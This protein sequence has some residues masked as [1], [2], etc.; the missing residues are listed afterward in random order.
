VQNS[1]RAT[2]LALPLPE[3]W[4]LRWQRSEAYHVVPMDAPDQP[5]GP[6]LAAALRWYEGVFW[7]KAR[8]TEYDAVPLAAEIFDAALHVNP[9]ETGEILAFVR[10]WGCLFHGGALDNSVWVTRRAFRELQRHFAW[11]QAL[12]HRAWRSP[13]VPSLWGDQ[14]AFV[15]ALQAVLPPPEHRKLHPSRWSDP[16]WPDLV[17]GA[18][19]SRSPLNPGAYPDPYVAAFVKGHFWN[20]HVRTTGRP[21]DREEMHWRAFGWAIEEHLQGVQPTLS[22]TGER[23]TPAWLVPRLIDLLWVELWNLETGG[24]AIR[25]CRHCRRWFPVDRRGKVYCSRRCTNRASAAA[26]YEARKNAATRRKRRTRR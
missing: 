22:W 23:P 16:R 8:R 18:V 19:M 7:T 13:A 1:H 2:D 24:A 3:E 5:L 14:D 4:G 20:W 25:Q 10:S 17:R 11:A 6:A 21:R 12:H 26:S 9:E 15:G